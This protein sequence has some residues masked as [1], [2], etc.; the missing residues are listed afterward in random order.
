M[1]DHHGLDGRGE[2]RRNGRRASTRSAPLAAAQGVEV[3]G[4]VGGVVKAV[5]FKG[6]DKVAAGAVLVQIDDLVQLAGLTAAELTVAVNQDALDRTQMLFT[7]KV[8]TS[9]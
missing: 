6:N 5:N 2:P 9:G 7:R 1:P 4:Q 3:A 8:A